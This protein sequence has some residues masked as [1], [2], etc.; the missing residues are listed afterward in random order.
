M[1]LSVPERLKL[2]ELL[3]EEASYPGIKEIYRTTLLLGLTD[4]EAKE[5]EAKQH[6]GMIQWNI[7]KALGLIVDIPIGEWMTNTFRE[8]LQER[9]REGNL[10]MPEISL[11][12]KF[13]LDYE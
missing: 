10:T 7:E 3:P 6:E 1:K 9:S 13:I 4:E 2:L 11:Y 12:E 5:V 8:I